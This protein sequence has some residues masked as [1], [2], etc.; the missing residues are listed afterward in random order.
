MRAL[1]TTCFLAML[2]LSV[3]VP[4]GCVL[5][6]RPS[7]RF[8]PYK[9]GNESAIED[10]VEVDRTS[11]LS[12]Y[13]TYKGEEYRLGPGDRM[14]IYR[15]TAKQD[16]PL[17]RVDTFVMPDGTVYF[18][19]AQGVMAKG[20]TTTELSQEL[21]R[22]LT[23][24]YKS[25]Q[26][27]V[28]LLEVKSSRY[29]VLGKVWKPA[30]YPLTQPTTLLEAL[31]RAGGLEVVGGTGTSEELADLSRSFV[32]RDGKPLP[33]DFEALVRGG[34]SRYN[35]YLKN[36]DFVYLPPKSTQEI[37]VLGWVVD[38][39]AVGYREGMGL[40][41][42]VAEVGGFKK[43]AYLQRSLLLRGSLTKPKVAIVNLDSIM[44]GKKQDVKVEAGDILWIPQSPWDRLERYLDLVV[45]TTVQTVAANE[46]IRSV[47]GEQSVGVSVSI[48]IAT[49]PGGGGAPPVSAPAP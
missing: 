31:A 43:N 32:V 30:L 40:V 16:D 13:T 5:G 45:N 47:Q 28:S 25:P 20:K 48:P 36:G 37:L 19:L 3:V 21:T 15:I 9:P 1:P 33:V 49:N 23:P 42:A 38:P 35:I 2:L 6:P 12:A 7:V 17:A 41:A 34:D 18:D 11:D 46:G 10:Q 26:V 24:F 22:A 4:T 29:F 14:Q 8:D 44:K 39:K 27:A